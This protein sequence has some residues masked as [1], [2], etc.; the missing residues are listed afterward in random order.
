MAAET[1]IFS[2][3]P[4]VI[5]LIMKIRIIFPKEFFTQEQLKKLNQYDLKFIEGKNIDLDKI[6]DLYGQEELIFSVNPAYVEDQWECLPLE[7]IKRMPGLKALCLSTTSY[8]WVDIAKLKQMN[9]LVTNAPGKSTN[10]V[11]EYNIY[12]M[13]AL[14]RKLPLILK[15]NWQMDMDKF[16][17]IE[18]KGLSAGIIGLGQIGSR[19]AELCQGNGLKVCYWNR[20]QKKSKYQSASLEKLFSN[21]DIIFITLATPT[22]LTGFINQKLLRRLKKTAIVI[23]TSDTHVL[24]EQFILKQVTKGSLGGFA[25]ESNDQE[26]HFNKLKGNVIYFPEQAFYT[27]ETQQRTAQILT[28]TILSIIKGK[29]INLVN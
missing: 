9:V 20:S 27:R 19:L 17:S 21:S 28:D 10:A 7:R 4:L 18:A 26:K 11:A 2:A 29:P 12:L 3:R 1:N 16:L 13:Y 5:E 23:S 24:D 22:E 15:N 6:T 25:A 14:L 8:S